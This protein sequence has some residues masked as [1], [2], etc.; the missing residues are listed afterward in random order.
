MMLNTVHC[1][2]VQKPRFS[3]VAIISRIK[4]R[5]PFLH[6]PPPINDIM[7]IMLSHAIT[8]PDLRQA[9]S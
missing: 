3:E 6:Q 5:S 9:S 7:S 8:F 1:V 4:P 2:T